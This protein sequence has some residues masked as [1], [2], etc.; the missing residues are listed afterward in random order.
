MHGYSSASVVKIV[1]QESS[2]LDE[3]LLVFYVGDWDPSGLHMSEVDLPKRLQAYGGNV[4]IRRL[5]LTQEDVT[6]DGLPSFSASSKR[7]D[8]R[9]QW[10][11]RRYGDTCWELDALNPALARE[12]LNQA[13]WDELDQDEW[14]RAEEIEEV[15]RASLREV[16]ASWQA[17]G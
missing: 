7:S 8:T 12:R 15:E 9:Y 2:K 16:L 10:F 5:A 1:A 6:D 11:T 14:Y 4:E 17:L 3:P 13:L